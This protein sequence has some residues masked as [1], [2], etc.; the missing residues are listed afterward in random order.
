MTVKPDKGN[1]SSG[2]AKSASRD[3]DASGEPTP[4]VRII[5]AKDAGWVSATGFVAPLTFVPVDPP[6]PLKKRRRR[7]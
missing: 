3:G 4:R 1:E 7:Q 5:T 6:R 2:T